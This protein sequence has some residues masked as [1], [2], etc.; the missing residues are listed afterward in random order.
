M[1]SDNKFVCLTASGVLDFKSAV[2]LAACSFRAMRVRSRLFFGRLPAGRRCALF[3]LAFFASV[4]FSFSRVCPVLCCFELT[5][6]LDLSGS[7]FRRAGEDSFLSLTALPRRSPTGFEPA[8]A[9]CF[10]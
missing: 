4:S 1:A 6:F 8:L 9:C 10:L 2:G 3:G 5:A 7:L